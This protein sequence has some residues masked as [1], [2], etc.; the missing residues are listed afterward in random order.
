M[1]IGEFVCLIGM[2]FENIRFYEWEGLLFVFEWFCNNYWC[3]G[4]V[5]VEWFYLIC[6]YCVLGIGLDDMCNLLGWMYCEFL[7]FELLMQVV[8][9]YFVYV[10]ECMV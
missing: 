5:Y 4:L 1:R 2:F 7:E 3:Y 9:D 8:W 10:E 6:N